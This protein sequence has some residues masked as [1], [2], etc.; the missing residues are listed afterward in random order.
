[1]S[2]IG[3]TMVSAN[4]FLLKPFA[5]TMYQNQK[6][7]NAARRRKYFAAVL[8]IILHIALFAAISNDNQSILDLFPDFIKELI[9]NP[10]VPQ[11]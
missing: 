1:M 11:A 3:N 7:E 10:E 2:E 5:Q 8:A 9:D 6:F 4:P